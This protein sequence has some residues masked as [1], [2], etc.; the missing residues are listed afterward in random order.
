MNKPQNRNPKG[1]LLTYKQ[2]AEKS[3]LGINVVMK[4]AKESGALLK[5]GRSARVDWAVFY[6]YITSKY[7]V[8]E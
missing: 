1:E 7:C 3:N 8:S 6:Q 2:V 5:I 4:L